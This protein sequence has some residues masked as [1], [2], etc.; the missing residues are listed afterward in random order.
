MVILPSQFSDEKLEEEYHAADGDGEKQAAILK[1]ANGILSDFFKLQDTTENLGGVDFAPDIG[2]RYGIAFTHGRGFEKPV[3]MAPGS[4]I[5]NQ[6][7][8]DDRTGEVTPGKP[9]ALNAIDDVVK[10]ETGTEPVPHYLKK[11]YGAHMDANEGEE[12]AALVE[13]GRKFRDQKNH[14][15]HNA[16]YGD[17]SYGDLYEQLEGAQLR[18]VRNSYD[19]TDYLSHIPVMFRREFLEGV[20]NRPKNRREFEARGF[21]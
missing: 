13:E 5:Y 8:R 20:L 18:Y 19:G 4:F 3:A 11:R 21:V 14:E 6:Y 16:D 15:V 12:A 10:Q 17:Y 1:K 7:D 2:W 9:D